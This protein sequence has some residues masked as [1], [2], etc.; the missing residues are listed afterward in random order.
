MRFS[1]KLKSLV[2]SAF[3]QGCD[4]VCPPLIVGLAAVLVSLHALYRATGYPICRHAFEFWLKM[5]L[6]LAA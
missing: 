3:I 5:H 1:R 4:A 2:P 6:Q